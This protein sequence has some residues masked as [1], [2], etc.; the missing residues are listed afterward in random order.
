MISR[1]EG[2]W[3][4]DTNGKRYFDGICMFFTQIGHSFG[5]EL[6]EAAR[7]ADG[8][9]Y[10]SS[11]TGATPTRRV[12]RA[13]GQD[14][15]DRP[16]AN[17]NRTFFCSGGSEANESIIKLVRQYHQDS[18]GG[19]PRRYKM[20]ARRTAYHGTTLR[21]AVAHGDRV[22]SET[23]FEPLTT[24]ACATC[25]TRTPTA[26]QDSTVQGRVHVAV[27][28]RRAPRE[29]IEDRRGRRPSPPS[30]RGAGAESGG[31]FTPP[32][33]ATS[34]GVAR[35]LPTSTG[36]C[37][38]PTRSSA[39]SAGSGYWF[40][41]ERLRHPARTSSPSPRASPRPTCRSADVIMTDS[42]R[43]A[44]PDRARTMF[45]ARHP[46][47]AAT[48]LSC[49]VA[50][51]NLEV[52][53]REDVVGNVKSQRALPRGGAR[54]K[55]LGER[56]SATS[57]APA[58]SCRSSYGAPT[59]RQRRR[60]PTRSAKRLLRG[61]L[62]AGSYDAGLICRADDRGDPVDPALAAADYAQPAR[63]STSCT[64]CSTRCSTRPGRR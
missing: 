40:G 29:S 4:W 18:D 28:A 50:L 23:P 39:G 1:G 6:G 30:L 13:L 25:P 57:A 46:R 22:G 21:R 37:S 26:A 58:T 17:L 9:D 59:R 10:R 45:T 38:W 61:F 20:L 55:K 3:L 51:K 35:D 53:E 48:P 2:C 44:L 31:T 52:M 19:G 27:P 11:S 32:R 62:L 5:A 7:E 8:D 36:S 12:D 41:S 56:S 24:R 64:T 42:H 33:R 49:A 47:T 60:S 16:P 15:R 63:S 43:R 14:R 54:Q 34:K